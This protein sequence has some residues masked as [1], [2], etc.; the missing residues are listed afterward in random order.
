MAGKYCE[1]VFC[2]NHA[3]SVLQ[4]HQIAN[5]NKAASDQV[6]ELNFEEQK[7]KDVTKIEEYVKKTFQKQENLSPKGKLKK[8][9]ESKKLSSGTDFEKLIG[10]NNSLTQSDI[11][12]CLQDVQIFYTD[13]IYYD[14][15]EAIKAGIV[16]PSYIKKELKRFASKHDL[17][18]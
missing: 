17:M 9:R 16:G 12:Q 3:Y 13:W 6:P 5:K 7:N 8:K 10:Q 1:V 15:P 11:L 14:E 4:R 2:L 18:F